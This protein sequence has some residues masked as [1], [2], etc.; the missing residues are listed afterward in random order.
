MIKK[1]EQIERSKW[2]EYVLHHEHGSVFH[3]SYIYEVYQNTPGFRAIAL[4]SV[5]SSGEIQGILTGFV[6]T[7]R[8]GLLARLSTRG[9]LMQSPIYSSPSCLNELLETYNKEYGKALVYTEIRDHYLS[10]LL[11]KAYD[12]C[13]SVRE[14]HYNIVLDLPDSH[15]ALWKQIGRKRKDGINKG[16]RFGFTITEQQDAKDIRDFHP[17]LIKQYGNI[18]LPIPPVV[19]FENCLKF[20]RDGYCKLIRLQEDG[21]TRISLLGFAFKQTFYAFYIGID[22]DAEFINKRP[23]DWFYYEVMKWCIDRG[24]KYFDWMGAGKPGVEYGVRDFKLQ[25]GGEVVD[26]GRRNIIHS[27]IKFKVANAGFKVLRKVGKV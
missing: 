12:G 4:A 1:I 15:E 26:F 13:G 6:Q 24:L 10:D 27:R 8:S 25:Y 16:K 3:T 9:V 19:F 20:D 5:D 14:G 23:V 18:G 22:Q 7:V 11:D 17:L 2:D 21:R